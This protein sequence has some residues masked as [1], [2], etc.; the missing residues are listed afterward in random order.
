MELANEERVPGVLEVNAPLIEE[1]SKHRTLVNIKLARAA[2]DRA[3]S[4]ASAIV[5]V[6][7]EVATYLEA[8]AA[9]AGKVRVVPNGVDVDR[10]V[11]RKSPSRSGAFTIGFV[12]TLKPWH[13]TDLLLKALRHVLAAGVDARIL[14]VGDGPERDALQSLVSELGVSAR[15]T[16]TGAVPPLQIAELLE[17]MDVA[18]A[19]YPRLDGFYFSPLKVYEYMAAALPVIASDIGQLASLVTHGRNGLLVAPGDICQLSSAIIRLHR[20]PRLCDSLGN[21]GFETAKHYTWGAVVGRI[22][23]IASASTGKENL[24]LAPA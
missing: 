4:S 14:I 18:V 10:F 11:R 3:F 23:Q 17:R 6:S 22:L 1:Q 2:T 9:S 16:F 21:A 7:T 24:E 12:G 19:P 15:V 20:D 8:F 13:G 5:A